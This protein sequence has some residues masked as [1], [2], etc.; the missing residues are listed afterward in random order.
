MSKRVIRKAT[1]DDIDSIVALGFEALQSDPYD[2][3][4]ISRVKVYNVATEC[5]SSSNNFAWVAEKDGEVVGAVCAIVHPIMF[6]EKRQASVVQYYCT[7]PGQGIKLLREFMRWAEGRPVIK[8]ICFTLEIN[9]D[10][11][12]GDLLAKLGLA[13]ELPVYLKLI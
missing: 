2:G 4:T 7:D 3:L 6:Y 10:P 12:I 5:V 1:P 13:G 11:R 8:M 9:S